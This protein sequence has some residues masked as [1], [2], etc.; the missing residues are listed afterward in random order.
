MIV[1]AMHQLIEVYVAPKAIR[2]VNGPEMTSETF[3]EWAKKGN[4]AAVYSA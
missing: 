1:R 4:Y 3:K 2:M